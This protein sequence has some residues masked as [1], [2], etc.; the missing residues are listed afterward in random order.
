MLH[1]ATHPGDRRR[2][3]DESELIP[4]AVEEMLRLH[5]PVSVGRIAMEDV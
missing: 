2:L 1:F 5:S 4:T 3:A